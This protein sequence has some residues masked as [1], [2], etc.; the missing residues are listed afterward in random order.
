MDESFF[1]IAVD[2][3]GH[4]YSGYVSP[5]TR[6]G[7]THSYHVVLDGVFSDI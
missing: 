3:Q 7:V 2:F 1:P 6:Q 5:E 4:H